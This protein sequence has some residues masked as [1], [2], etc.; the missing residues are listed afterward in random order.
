[1]LSGADMTSAATTNLSRPPQSPLN[2]LPAFA[3]DVLVST[4]E[5]PVL[6]E[7]FPD[8]LLREFCDFLLMLN[9]SLDVSRAE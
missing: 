6:S 8:P 3:G 7:I 5:F 2:H 1:M 9:G 4:P